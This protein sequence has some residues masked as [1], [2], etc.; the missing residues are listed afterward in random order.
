M[1]CNS[2]ISV[3]TGLSLAQAQIRLV[4]PKHDLK[5]DVYGAITKDDIEEALLKDPEIEA[6]YITSPTFEG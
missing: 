6:V 2:H 1:Q 4:N 3:F 5:F